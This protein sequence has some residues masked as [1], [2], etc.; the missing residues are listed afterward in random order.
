MN[1]HNFGRNGNCDVAVTRHQ[2]SPRAATLQPQTTAI[3]DEFHQIISD[4]FP[5]ALQL[6]STR[7]PFV[8]PANQLSDG[9]DGI[10]ELPKNIILPKV[11]VI[12]HRLI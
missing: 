12:R 3:F 6:D 8:N 11:D 7:L 5:S 9:L 1:L 2:A 10:D 4:L